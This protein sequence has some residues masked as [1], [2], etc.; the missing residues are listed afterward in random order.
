MLSLLILIKNIAVF[1]KDIDI[2]NQMFV[3]KDY[4]EEIRRKNMVMKSK[5]GFRRYLSY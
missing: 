5:M 3:S 1:K 2:E 4:F